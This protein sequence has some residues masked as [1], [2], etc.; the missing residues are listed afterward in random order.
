MR[1]QKGHRSKNHFVVIHPQ[2]PCRLVTVMKRADWCI[3]ME[4][5]LWERS[6]SPV[7]AHWC[8]LLPMQCSWMLPTTTSAPYRWVCVRGLGCVQSNWIIYAC[9]ADYLVWSEDTSCRKMTVDAFVVHVWQL[10]SALDSLPSS[11]M[12][13]MACCATG[14][15]RGY[16]ELVPHQVLHTFLC[17]HSFTT[18]TLWFSR[19]I[20]LIVGNVS[21]SYYSLYQ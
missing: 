8:P 9:R 6:S 12:V 14:S 2:R 1:A 15:T 17:K 18:T 3:V 20:W 7:F 16:D 10:R 21:A 19:R 11:A 13:S 4:A 5:S